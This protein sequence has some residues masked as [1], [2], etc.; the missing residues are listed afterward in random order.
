[1]LARELEELNDHYRSLVESVS[2]GVLSVDEAVRTLKNMSTTDAEG[3][4]WSLDL[5][6]RFLA[7]RPGETPI[8]IDPQRFANRN[9]PGPW[10]NTWSPAQD[11]TAPPAQPGSMTHLGGSRPAARR[12]SPMPKIS[13]G[14]LIARVGGAG[15]LRTP[16]IVGVALLAIVLV[17]GSQNS[18]ES[19]GSPIEVTDTSPTAP[20][21]PT[22]PADDPVLAAVSGLLTQIGAPD[23][24]LAAVMVDPG[25]GSGFI[26][27]RAQFAGYRAVGL[28]LVTNSVKAQDGGYLA[29]VSLQDGSGNTIISG[30]AEIVTKGET[31]LLAGWPELGR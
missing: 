23:T 21:A 1:M 18:T 9:A 13:L 2:G 11:L 20:G 29:V 28:Q 22:T 27:R 4:V 19:P 16:I 31:L 12:K 5:E 30:K 3:Y 24:D 14:A 15:R 25:T 10:D 26:L 6:G 17:W 7:G 8:L